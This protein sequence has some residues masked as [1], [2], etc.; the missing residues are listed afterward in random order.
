VDKLLKSV[1]H[2]QCDAKPT[3]TFPAIGHHHPLTG[4]NLYCLVTEAR[5]WVNNR[6][7]CA[8]YCQRLSSG[9]SQGRKSVNPG[10][11]GWWPI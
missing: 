2:D 6:P 4:T 7:H 9:T 1:T 11:P 8:T 5:V 3:V 10:L